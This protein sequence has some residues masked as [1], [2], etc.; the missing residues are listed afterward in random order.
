MFERFY[1]ATKNAFSTNEIEVIYFKINNE[2]ESQIIKDIQKDY[3]KGI[4]KEFTKKPVR[5][6]KK[7]L[8]K[9]IEIKT[10]NDYYLF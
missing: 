10:I 8:P 9:D 6:Y 1:K 5:V 7:D 2:I 4:Y 3:E